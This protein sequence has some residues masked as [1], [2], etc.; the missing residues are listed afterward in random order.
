MSLGIAA[1]RDVRL[2][3][4]WSRSTQL[5][6]DW[7]IPVQGQN[8]SYA[9]NTIEQAPQSLGNVLVTWSPS[10]L[11]GGR[12]GAE[13][14]HTGR[15]YT[16][17]DNTHDYDGF[18]YW[19]FHASHSISG[20]GD[21]FA[22]LVNATNTKYAELVAYNAFTREQYTPGNPRMLFV[23]VRWTAARGGAN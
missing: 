11:R 1:T 23:G 10:W 3:V 21:V 9:G 14:A 15:Y 6:E 12:F 17:P 19:T 16:D 2:D 22:R 8:R 5:Y 18:D 4:A 20:V 13:W 7:V